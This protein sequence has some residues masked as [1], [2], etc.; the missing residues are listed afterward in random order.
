MNQT[1][2]PPSNPP[3]S[4]PLTDIPERKPWDTL[5]EREREVAILIALG[6]LPREIPVKLGI[7][8]KTYDTHRAHL[9]KKLGCANSV[10]VARLLIR[11]GVVAP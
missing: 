8:P 1:A 7:A 11:E 6:Y 4:Q 9:M 10:Q 3:A 2:H 5:S